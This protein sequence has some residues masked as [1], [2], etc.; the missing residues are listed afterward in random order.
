MFPLMR[1]FRGPVFSRTSTGDMGQ[2][3]RLQARAIDRVKEQAPAY[4]RALL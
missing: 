3:A 4:Q 2:Q 1:C